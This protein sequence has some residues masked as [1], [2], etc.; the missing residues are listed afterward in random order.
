[1]RGGG[2]ATDVNADRRIGR[3]TVF[4]EAGLHLG[5]MRLPRHATAAIQHGH[6]FHE[7][8]LILDGHGKHAVGEEVH[9]LER[10]DVFVILGDQ[11][12]GYPEAEDLSLVN[13]LYDPTLLGIPVADL[14]GVP[15]YHALFKV[16]PRV[17]PGGFRSRLRLS[18][19]QLAQAM[20][21]V[22]RI[23]E[24]I[25]EKRH[26][27]GFIAIAQLMELIGYLSRCYSQ[28][29]PE[30]ERPVTQISELLG[31][32]ERHHAE[33]LTVADLLRVAHM[34]QTT[35]MRTFGRIMGRSP[36][37]HLIRLRISKARDL[38]R[39]TELSVTDVA[40]RVG[41][42]DSNYFT[43]QFRRV[44]GVTPRTYRAR[45]LSQRG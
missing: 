8:V 5:V 11:T 31:H 37:D 23:E 6:D 29:E 21:Y 22:A 2:R 34:S 35:L 10:G 25:A 4:P 44:T 28:L 15:G 14:G 17:R 43:R 3:E 38:L 19:E 41:F 27:H 12:H 24:E 45:A 7:L 32:M 13:V 16:E 40:F 39:R 18:T 9:E 30:A 33:A 36:I 42:N 1:M 20:Q 26:G